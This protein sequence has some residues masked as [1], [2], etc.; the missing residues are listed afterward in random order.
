M[1]RVFLVLIL[2]MLAMAG[3]HGQT[4]YYQCVEFEDNNGVKKKEKGG[5]YLTFTNNRK[6]VYLSDEKGYKKSKEDGTIEY[7]FTT[8]QGFDMIGSFQY[9]KTQS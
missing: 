8:V 1:K 3:V 4:N 5:A 7:L 9:A 6:T 2:G